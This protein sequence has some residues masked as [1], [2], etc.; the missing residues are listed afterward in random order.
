MVKKIE[1]ESDLSPMQRIVIALVED[2]YT[3]RIRNTW[4]LTYGKGDHRVTVHSDGSTSEYT[5][6]AGHAP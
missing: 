3:L 2:G 1:S 6:A 5:T 4:S